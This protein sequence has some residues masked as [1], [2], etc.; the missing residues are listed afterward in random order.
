MSNPYESSFTL[1]LAEAQ[2]LTS[3]VEHNI[4]NEKPKGR[5]RRPSMSSFFSQLNQ[6]ENQH[7][8]NPH[9]SPTPVDVAAAVRL[10]QD[11]FRLLSQTA[12]STENGGFLHQLID[13]LDDLIDSP[14]DK[15]GVPQSYLDELHRVPK[16]QLKKTDECPICGE[17]F[18]DDQ[19]PLVVELPCHPTHRFDLDCVGP[20]LRLNGTC[21]LDRKELMMKKEVVKDDE[22]EEDD[23]GMYA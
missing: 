18:L 13:S 22:D 17:P 4:K 8:N 16:K 14:P 11:Q 15:V 7:P 6:V 3:A 2:S 9:A 23:G 19:Y 21:P 20:W 1:S 10:L 12:P 5:T